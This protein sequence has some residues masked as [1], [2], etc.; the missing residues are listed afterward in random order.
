M[1][2]R[3]SRHKSVIIYGLSLAALLFLLK[4]LELRFVIIDHSFEVYIGCIAIIFTALGIWLALKLSRPKIETRVETVVVEKEIY[5]KD[6]ATNNTSFIMNEAEREKLGLSN[7]ELEVLQLM[8]EGL[9]N[10]E[11]ADRLFVSL[12]TIKTHSS[13][14]FE[15]MDVKRRTQA[16]E[17]AKRLNIIQ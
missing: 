8:S 13:K 4:W 16:V 11:I 17:M 5:V 15:K 7:R 12:N 1:I 14:L 6:N 10:Q 9:S 2:S 3:I